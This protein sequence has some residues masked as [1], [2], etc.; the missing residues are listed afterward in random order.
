LEVRAREYNSGIALWDSEALFQMGLENLS[1]NNSPSISNLKISNN[2]KNSLSLLVENNYS[3]NKELIL[4][5]AQE[6]N[7]GFN[8]SKIKWRTTTS[9]SYYL[10]KD[11]LCLKPEVPVQSVSNSLK[12]FITTYNRLISSYANSIDNTI[13]AAAYLA[14]DY[15]KIHPTN[16]ANKRVAWTLVTSFLQKR[17]NIKLDYFN[18][19]EQIE[20]SSGIALVLLDND[21][22]KLEE[23]IKSKIIDGNSKPK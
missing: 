1:L 9:E 15:L 14:A 19:S 4:Q 21:T 3:I 12:E 16:N 23:L 10:Y 8:N 2:I 5:I 22:T 11:G 17:H 20:F 13:E 6:C 7:K 18:G